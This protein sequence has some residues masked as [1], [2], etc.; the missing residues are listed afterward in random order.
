MF[1]W[2]VL[3]SISNFSLHKG[4]KDPKISPKKKEVLFLKPVNKQIP[5]RG[6]EFHYQQN[7]KYS[8]TPGIHTGQTG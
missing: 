1:E 7:T 4:I 2:T 3:F 6:D 5:G 8:G